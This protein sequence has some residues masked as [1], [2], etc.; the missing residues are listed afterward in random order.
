[1]R[2]IYLNKMKLSYKV[3]ITADTKY[4]RKVFIQILC[5]IF[6]GY[7]YITKRYEVE[8]ECVYIYT[9][10]VIVLFLFSRREEKIQY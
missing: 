4:L 1:M 3:S 9:F 6:I 7:I 2:C 5:I 8:F 10:S